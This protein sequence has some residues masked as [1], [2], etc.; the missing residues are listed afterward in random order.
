MRGMS[1][2]QW[3]PNALREMG[4]I[5]GDKGREV[6]VRW[7]HLGSCRTLSSTMKETEPLES[8]RQRNDMIWHKFY[9]DQA[10]YC[11]ENRLVGD[12]G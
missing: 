6:R 10:D 3:E 7:D 5:G 9:Q 11:V 4:G 12:K 8:F 2:E 1:Q